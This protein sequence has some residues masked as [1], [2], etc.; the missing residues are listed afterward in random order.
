MGVC[1]DL[2]RVFSRPIRKT[3][4]PICIG[5]AKHVIWILI[6]P[7]TGVKATQSDKMIRKE[8]KTQVE[9]SDFLGWLDVA[10]N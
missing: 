7:I 3:D 2:S 9:F 5:Q 8:V 6:C 1:E 10:D 4:P